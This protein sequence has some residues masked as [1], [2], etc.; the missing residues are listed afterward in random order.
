[1]PPLPLRCASL[2]LLLLVLGSRLACA[3]SEADQIAP[4]LAE[5]ILSP[6]AATFQLKQYLLRHV[7]PP[8]EATTASDWTAK[9]A[10]LREHLLRDVVFH[11]WPK[12]WVEAPPRFEDLGLI[13]TGKGYRL[14]RLRYEIVPGFQSVA[15]LYEP[16]RMDGKV[17]AIVNV[18]GHVGPPGKSVE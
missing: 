18:N 8:P 17:P 14:R 9:G 5:E 12:E 11:G 16:E 3:Q 13:A 1:M 6:A 10:R 4:I 7:A 2:V 15:L